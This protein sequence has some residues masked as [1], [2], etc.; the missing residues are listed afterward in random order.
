MTLSIIHEVF[1][2]G[3]DYLLFTFDGIY[4]LET[5]KKLAPR[6]MLAVEHNQCFRLVEDIRK[7]TIQIKS[8]ELVKIQKFQA[9]YAAKYG[10]IYQ[11]ITQAIVI[12]EDTG[13]LNDMKF[14][15]TLSNNYGTRVKIFTDMAKAIRWVTA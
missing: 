13:V 11:Q 8:D 1:E 2:S 10:N 6:F 15:E 4:N 7:A 12:N 9:E 5:I 3:K 14:Y